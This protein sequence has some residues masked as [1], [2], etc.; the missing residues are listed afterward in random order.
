MA[1]VHHVLKPRPDPDVLSLVIPVYNEEAVLPELRRRLGEFLPTIA[2][3]SEVVIVNDGSS[4]RTLPMLLQWAEAD[5]RIK[6]LGLARNFGHQAAITA[7]LDTASGD[8]IVVMDAD[9]QDPPEVVYEMLAEYRKGYDVVYGQRSGREGEGWFKRLTAWAFYRFM[10]RF[11]YKDLPPDSGDFRLVSRACLDAVKS[12]RETHR[13]LRGMVAWVGFPQTAVRYHRHKR[14]AGETKY[15]FTKMMRFAWTAAISFSPIPL[16]LS[17]ACGLVVAFF[18]F[19]EGMYALCRAIL[20]YYV[21]PGWSSLMAV[22]CLVGGGILIS[23]GVL[24]EYVGKIFEETKDRPLYIVS[25]KANLDL[26][27]KPR[28]SVSIDKGAI[29][30]A[31]NEW[32]VS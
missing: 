21:V 24:G 31:V 28:V 4:D 7:G 15:P 6:V 14:V 8:A 25:S 1:A 22:M 11:V 23:I 18:G 20:G 9:L 10:S 26:P 27:A 12:M 16:R 5:P 29:D 30:K 19:A 32:T 13:F 2:C 3:D 17:F